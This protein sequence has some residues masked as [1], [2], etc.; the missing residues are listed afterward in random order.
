MGATP[1]SFIAFREQIA[2]F[3]GH[4]RVLL[5]VGAPHVPAES[6]VRTELGDQ[7]VN[8]LGHF[9]KTPSAHNRLRIPRCPLQR[10]A[11]ATANDV[12]CS[13]SSGNGICYRPPQRNEIEYGP[14]LWTLTAPLPGE[15]KGGSPF[16]RVRFSISG[17]FV[18][19]Q[20]DRASLLSVGRK[21]MTQG[22]IHID[23]SPL[24]V[25]RAYVESRRHD[26]RPISAARAT[27]AIRTLLVDCTL[28]D[29]ELLELVA[30]FAADHGLTIVDESA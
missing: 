28:S 8:E 24:S 19:N 26:L 27:L 4:F 15:R 16:R 13:C 17:R 1:D 14:F 22:E 18:G 6:N 23:R 3:I 12:Y 21:I 20:L 30:R 25:A 2:W 5:W 7:A 10:L 11:E 29:G 9:R